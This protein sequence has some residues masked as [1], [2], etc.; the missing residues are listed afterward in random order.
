MRLCEIS[1]LTGSFTNRKLI[2]ETP[3]PPECVIMVTGPSTGF[4]PLGRVV[5][6][7]F[8]IIFITEII[9]IVILLIGWTNQVTNTPHPEYNQLLLVTLA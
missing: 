8:T 5:T 7:S 2:V 6:T 9:T 3:T 1:G 4:P